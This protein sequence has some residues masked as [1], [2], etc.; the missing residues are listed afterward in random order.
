M[1]L[2]SLASARLR[3]GRCQVPQKEAT[4]QRLQTSPSHSHSPSRRH[5]VSHLQKKALSHYHSARPP[6]WGIGHACEKLRPVPWT[7]G[8]HTTPIHHHPLWYACLL[9]Q[10]HIASP[11]EEELEKPHVILYPP[12][13]GYSLN[14]VHDCY[15]TQDDIPAKLPGPVQIVGQD[16]KCPVRGHPY[17][18]VQMSSIKEC[19][20]GDHW[21][22]CL[23]CRTGLPFAERAHWQRR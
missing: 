21:L 13:R 22:L 15:F 12:Q 19:L 4:F 18:S 14:R 16:V 10:R 17:F 23:S 2:P 1:I 20:R 9:M 5:L 8:S 6:R 11:F 3:G 7:E